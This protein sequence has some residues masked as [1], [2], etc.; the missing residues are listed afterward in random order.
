[1]E[2]PVPAA[3]VGWFQGRVRGGGYLGATLRKRLIQAALRELVD[4]MA[5][6]SAWRFLRLCGSQAAK[7]FLG[8]RADAAG[9]LR[10]P[11]IAL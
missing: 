1:M 4:G 2:E 3:F 8:R 5:A 6:S 7:F 9:G 10:P 11:L